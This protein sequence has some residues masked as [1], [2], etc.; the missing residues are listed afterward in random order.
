M[1]KNAV[2]GVAPLLGPTSMVRSIRNA[3]AF[4]AA[5]LALLAMFPDSANADAGRIQRGSR[6][7]H[8]NCERC[9]SVDRVTPSNLPLAPAFRTLGQRYPVESLREALAEGIVTRHQNMPEFR[10]ER[11]QIDDFLAFLTSIQVSR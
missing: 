8:A 9:H 7:A 4:A 5:A 3:S 11:D 2:Y 10:L 1:L 6:F